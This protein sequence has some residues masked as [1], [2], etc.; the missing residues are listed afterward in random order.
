MKTYHFTGE[1]L[2]TRALSITADSLE[3]ARDLYD[4]CE[5]EEGHDIDCALQDTTE[6]DWSGEE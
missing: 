4:A 3:E 6:P 5:W 1:F 2:V